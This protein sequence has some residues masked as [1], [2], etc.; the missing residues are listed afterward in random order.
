MFLTFTAHIRSSRE[1]SESRTSGFGEGSEG[2]RCVAE[3]LA[4]A[5]IEGEK[6]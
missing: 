6:S 4:N 3:N 2:D 1:C 5:A